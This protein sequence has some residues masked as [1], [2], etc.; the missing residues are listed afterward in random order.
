MLLDGDVESCIAGKV[1]LIDLFSVK[2]IEEPYSL[3]FE[4]LEG[5]H[6]PVSVL[7]YHTCR[8]ISEKILEA[9]VS[10]RN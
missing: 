6:S 3:K 8:A 2:D 5:I 10:P 7:L 1:K 4:E 9:K